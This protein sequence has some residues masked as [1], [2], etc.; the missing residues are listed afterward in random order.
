M[1][2]VCVSSER[3]C[4]ERER[5]QRVGREPRARPTRVDLRRDRR[6]RLSTLVSP[7]A[8]PTSGCVCATARPEMSDDHLHDDGDTATRPHTQS[9][10][11]RVDLTSS[12]ERTRPGS[13]LSAVHSAHVTKHRRLIPRRCRWRYSRSSPSIG[14]VRR[15]R[16]ATR[17]R[18][19]RACAR[20]P[21]R[22]RARARA[23][24]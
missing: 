13:A 14:L 3:V 21:S 4:R 24:A 9:V 8:F 18:G 22:G 2:C 7:P 6:R 15:P 10:S 1:L 16:F 23:R 12:A 11:R 17:A 19:S 20:A 5:P